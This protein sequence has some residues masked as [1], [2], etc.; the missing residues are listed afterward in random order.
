M[1]AG[2]MER[3]RNGV[4]SFPPHFGRTEREREKKRVGRRAIWDEIRGEREGEQR[5][6]RKRETGEGEEG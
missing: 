4:K 3:C 1:R 6:E 5:R 2:K